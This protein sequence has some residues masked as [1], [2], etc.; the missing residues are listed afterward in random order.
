VPLPKTLFRNFLA[1]ALVRRIGNRCDAVVVPTEA[2]EHYLRMIGVKSSIF[3]VPTG[4][5]TDRFGSCAKADLSNLRTRLGIKSHDLVLVSASRI[6]VEKNIDFLLQAI[7]QLAQNCPRTFKLVLIGEGPEKTRLIKVAAQSG[8]QDT[9][10]F[11][12]SVSPEQMPLYYSLGDVFVFA[13]TSE[14][15]GMVILEAMASGM[16]VVAVRASGIDDFVI[17]GVTGFKTTEHKE[18]W[19]EKIRLLLEDDRLRQRMATQANTLAKKYGM[20]TFGAR[21]EQ[22]YAHVLY[23]K[24]TS[25]NNDSGS[26]DISG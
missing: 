2:S 15:Q 8:L 13:S 7:G 4:I 24:K 12:G 18:V 26:R 6:S 5:E 9:V 10:I 21:M 11:A 17:N 3:V 20:D 23:T 19:A 22:V 16:P 14:T 25:E 1:H